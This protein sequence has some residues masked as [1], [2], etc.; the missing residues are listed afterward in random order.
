LS[1]RCVAIQKFKSHL[2][3]PTSNSTLF[4]SFIIIS[5][6]YSTTVQ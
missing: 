2:D 1:S 3:T 6:R 4:S 5:L